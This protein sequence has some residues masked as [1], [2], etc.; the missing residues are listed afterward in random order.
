MNS[1]NVPGAWHLGLGCEAI[2][3]AGRVRVELLKRNYTGELQPQLRR[4]GTFAEVAKQSAS[5]G[6]FK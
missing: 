4:P 3:V 6:V 1:H 2:G 5:L